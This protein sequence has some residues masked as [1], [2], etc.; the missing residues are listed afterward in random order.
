MTYRS[1][2]V[3]R[4]LRGFYDDRRLGVL[5]G[6]NINQD[7]IRSWAFGIVRWEY[8]GGEN[9]L[10]LIVD[11]EHRELVTVQGVPVAVILS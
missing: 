5:F 4:R 9:D 7:M 11:E 3:T 6:A 2:L 8:G 10:N 1:N